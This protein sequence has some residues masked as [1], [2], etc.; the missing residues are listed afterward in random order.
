MY[1]SLTEFFFKI[2]SLAMDSM[3]SMKIMD[4]CWENDGDVFCDVSW[5][6]IGIYWD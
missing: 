4:I 3:D 1:E 2:P 6:M 5:D